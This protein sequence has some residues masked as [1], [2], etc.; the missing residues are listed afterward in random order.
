MTNG[1]GEARGERHDYRNRGLSDRAKAG[2]RF[3]RG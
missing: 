1:S 3:G 2:K